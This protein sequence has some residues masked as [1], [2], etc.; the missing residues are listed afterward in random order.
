MS[1]LKI[2]ET[3]AARLR[4]EGYRVSTPVPEEGKLDWQ[5][6]SLAEAVAIKKGFLDD[7][8]EVIRDAD[9]VLIANVEKHGID[10]YV[11]ANTLME[12]ACG[13]ALRKPV[14][15][16]HP[17]GMQ[18]CQIEAC[19]ISSGILHGDAARLKELLA[20]LSAS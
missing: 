12:A 9:I 5:N 16:L 20:D 17:V 7:Y 4:K 14:I 11:G 3:L 18:A 2:M 19:A 15:F 10:G 1:A 8:F 6:M 13:H